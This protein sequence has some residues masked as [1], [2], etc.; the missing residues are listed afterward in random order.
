MNAALDDL[1]RKFGSKYSLVVAVA[2]RGRDLMDGA[3]RL[4]ESRSNKPVSIALQEL[5]EGKLELHY[6]SQAGDK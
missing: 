5:A 6:P 3:P 1:V 2:K 4:V